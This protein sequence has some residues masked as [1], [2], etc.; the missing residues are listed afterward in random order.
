MA[1]AKAYMTEEEFVRLPDDGNKYELVEGEAKIV[2]PVYLEHEELVGHLME[3]FRP[4][5]RGSGRLYASSAGF[6]MS[7]GNIRSPDVSFVRKERLPEGRSPRAFGQGA[8]D[9]CVEIISAS[10]DR[11]EM[12]RKVE[13]YFASGARQVWHLFPETQRLLIYTSPAE[14]VP[15]EAEDEI[16]GGDLFPG[17]RCKVAD[18]FDLGD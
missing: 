1:I 4:F 2:S 14:S 12:Q 7:T 9:L 15:L 10:E 6:R 13:E 11:Q 17:F 8:P 3:L 5:S 16:D 18:L